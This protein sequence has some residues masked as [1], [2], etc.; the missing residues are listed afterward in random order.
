MSNIPA[1]LRKR[2][3]FIVDEN[4]DVVCND[5]G[6]PVT[7]KDKEDAEKYIKEKNING[8]VR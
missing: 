8:F 4:N 1:G 6:L 5:S 3:F 2:G 7:F